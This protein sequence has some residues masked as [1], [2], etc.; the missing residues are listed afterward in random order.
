MRSALM[1][2]PAALSAAPRFLRAWRGPNV[3]RRFA[4]GGLL[5]SFLVVLVVLVCPCE[6]SAQAA[7]RPHSERRNPVLT[8]PRGAVKEL[9]QRRT[10]SST[11]CATD[12]GRR[13]T[14]VGLQPVRWRDGRGVLRSFDFT[15]RRQGE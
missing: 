3:S 15:L 14:R 8:A 5:L 9:V 12:D 6:A 10:E 4:G 11:S 7:Q 1:Y 13:I 2:G